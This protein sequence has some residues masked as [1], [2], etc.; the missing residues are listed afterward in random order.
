MADFSLGNDLSAA[1]SAISAVGSLFGSEAKASGYQQEANLYGQA[2]NLENLN[3][4]YA[5]SGTVVK[6][7]LTAR[8]ATKTIGA[9]KAAVGAHGFEEAGSNL[10]L[11]RDS[12]AQ[13]GIARGM[14]NIQGGIEAANF[15]EQELGLKAQQAG[16]QAA[17][18]A[19]QT[20]GILGAL[21][22]V[23][24]IAAKFI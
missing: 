2:A 18:S 13:A 15:Q 17:A 8:Q 20:G 10:Y 14:V 16:A 9:Q 22:S 3:E 5:E 7:A 21:G 19:A 4:L 23:A 1:G 12:Q 11:L 24:G 6:E